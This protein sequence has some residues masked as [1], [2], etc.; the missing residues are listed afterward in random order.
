[1]KTPIYT[2]KDIDPTRNVKS[3]CI[4]CKSKEYSYEITTSYSDEVQGLFSVWSGYLACSEECFNMFLLSMDTLIER[5]G[6]VYA[7]WVP[8]YKTAD[9]T[10]DNFEN[11][12]VNNDV[13]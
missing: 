2:L 11:I 7:P 10:L 3:S 13:D 9:I 8:F 12:G 5:E 1:M 6:Y 4:T